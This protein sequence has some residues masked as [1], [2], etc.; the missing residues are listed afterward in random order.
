MRGVEVLKRS[1]T[2]ERGVAACGDSG[3]LCCNVRWS[4]IVSKI[5][6]V[7]IPYYKVSTFTK[8]FEI[9][10]MNRNRAL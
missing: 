10:F 6:I 7:V 5:H 9:K 2:F 4:K 3:D 1:A 8:I